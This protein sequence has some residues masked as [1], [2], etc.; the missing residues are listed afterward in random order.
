MLEAC[1]LRSDYLYEN[2]Y[3]GFRAL[4]IES[5][6]CKLVS[7]NGNEFK[8]FALLASSIEDMEVVV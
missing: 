8:A 5:G 4:A 2:K 3:D 7:R 1:P 6:R